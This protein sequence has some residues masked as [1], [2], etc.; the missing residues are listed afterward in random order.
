[1]KSLISALTLSLV[2]TG[3][4]AGTM[5]PPAQPPV[6][7]YTYGMHLDIARI[8]EMTDLST[9]CGIMPARMTYEDSRMQRNTIEYLVWGTGCKNDY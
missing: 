4:L 6:T 5:D 1:M 8:V 3:A 2:A 9:F 7:Q